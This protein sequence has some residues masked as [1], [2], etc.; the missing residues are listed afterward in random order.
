MYYALNFNSTLFFPIQTLSEKV[1]AALRLH[2]ENSEETANFVEY[3]DKFFDML[4]CKK[5]HN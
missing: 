2:V 4:K 5:F 3:F 1:A